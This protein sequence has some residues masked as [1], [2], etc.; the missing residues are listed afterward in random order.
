MRFLGKSC[1]WSLPYYNPGCTL[2]GMETTHNS[3]ILH[4]SPSNVIRY[5]R[6]L[7]DTG[8]LTKAQAQRMMKRWSITGALALQDGDFA[9]FVTEEGMNCDCGKGLYC[10]SNPQFRMKLRRIVQRGSK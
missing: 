4:T 5:C 8:A 2:R 9:I 1:D 3:K 10:P 7:T 6:E